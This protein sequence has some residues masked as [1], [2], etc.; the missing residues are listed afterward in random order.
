[1][2]AT[3]SPRCHTDAELFNAGIAR[4]ATLP[5]PTEGATRRVAQLLA[6]ALQQESSSEEHV[7]AA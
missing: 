2:S 7:P 1:M 4:A 3:T 5:P 6:A